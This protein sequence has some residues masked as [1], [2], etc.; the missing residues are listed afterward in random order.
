MPV[1]MQKVGETT[2]L[3]GDFQRDQEICGSERLVRKSIKKR[4]KLKQ[5]IVH[6]NLLYGN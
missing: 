6:K 5:A 4:K 3:S 2:R 1:G